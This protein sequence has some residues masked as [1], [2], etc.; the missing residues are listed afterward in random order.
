MTIAALNKNFE[1]R[2][3][4][5]YQKNLNKQNNYSQTELFTP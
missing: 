3:A 5:L 4:R 2:P 1:D